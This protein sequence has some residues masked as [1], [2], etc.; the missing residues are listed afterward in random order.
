M[1]GVWEGVGVALDKCPRSPWCP[2]PAASTPGTTCPRWATLHILML[3]LVFA[4]MHSHRPARAPNIP[5]A[6]GYLN[7][8]ALAPRSPEGPWTSCIAHQPDPAFQ[9][10]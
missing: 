8:P 3:M 4:C 7:M 6:G 2:L 10:A 5:R 1:E 9:T